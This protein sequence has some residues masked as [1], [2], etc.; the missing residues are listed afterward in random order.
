MDMLN[1]DI[2]LKNDASTRKKSK[3][4][5]SDEDNAGFHFIAFIPVQNKVWKLDGLERQP[6]DLG[7]SKRM[8]SAIKSLV[9]LRAIPRTN[10]QRRLGIAGS[11]RDRNSYGAI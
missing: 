4:K 10:R 9:S 2:Q 3:A 5:D 11:P 6:Q 1:A 7:E 8:T